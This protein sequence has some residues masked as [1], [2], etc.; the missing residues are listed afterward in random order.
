LEGEIMP[1]SFEQIIAEA[2]ET[3]ARN[4]ARVGKPAKAAVRAVEDPAREN[5]Y[6]PHRNVYQWYANTCTC[7]RKWTEF[8]GIYEERRHQRLA[9]THWVR[10]Q[11]QP[12]N[13]LPRAVEFKPVEVPYCEECIDATPKES[14]PQS[15]NPHNAPT[16]DN[17]QA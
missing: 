12:L 16:G 5:L 15:E 14:V 4:K 9:H 1:L 7:G 2:E 3:V 8:D 11:A 13:N 17:R 10:L 6:I